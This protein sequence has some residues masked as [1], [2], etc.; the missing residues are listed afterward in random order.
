MEKQI[1]AYKIDIA[2]E[3]IRSKKISLERETNAIKR[4]ILTE[5]AN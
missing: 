3:G 2:S 1:K 5:K 4:P